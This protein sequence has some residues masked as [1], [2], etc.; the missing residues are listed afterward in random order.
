MNLP[1]H[2]FA[3]C[4]SLALAACNPSTPSPADQAALDAAKSAATKLGQTV[5]TRL[6]GALGAGGP[7][8]A[9]EV[10]SAEA[11]DIAKNVQTETG[12]R[13]GRS[14]TKLRNPADAPPPW[15]ADWLKAQGDTKA[16][17]VQGLATVVDTDKGRV[18]RFLKPLAIETP[19]LL[20]HGDPATIAPEVKAT[21]AAKYPDDKATGYALGDLRG[22]I[23][24][25]VDVKR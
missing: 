11:Q 18:A 3:V 25:E 24:A 6:V 5:K 10:C 12:A 13:L 15:V 22:A 20:C 23:W 21:L 19:C 16:E 1:K 8:K 17:N 2:L 4:L 14:S 9:V 7:Q